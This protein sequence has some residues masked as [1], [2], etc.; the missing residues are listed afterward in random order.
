MRSDSSSQSAG[1]V[2]VDYYQY[3]WKDDP[4][5][6]GV[7][8][9]SGN[10][11][12]L[13]DPA[14]LD[15]L[16]RWYNASTQLGCGGPEVG[17]QTSVTCVRSKSFEQLLNVTFIEDPL[18]ALLA[19]FD[20]TADNRLVFSDY[21]TRGRN[22]DFAKLP[23]LVGNTF[24]EAGFFKI[25]A[26]AGGDNFTDTQWALFNLAIFQCGSRQAAQYRVQNGVDVWRYLYIGN[27]TNVELTIPPS[28]SY[29][30]SEIPI[31]WGTAEFATG[32]ADTTVESATSQYLMHMW[33]SFAQDP[34]ILTQDLALP[35]Y[36][37]NSTR[38]L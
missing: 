37:P 13:S 22:G 19:G 34:S 25:L 15:N 23:L 12:T 11:Q 2:S 7:I 29:H 24:N 18:A 10:A 35:Q 28:G 14:P 9:E 36:S 5:V 4:I 8:Q 33:A 27:F 38:P 20:P 16:Q 3:A 32:L 1:G 21:S 30:T 31:V 17:I 26:Q 6:A